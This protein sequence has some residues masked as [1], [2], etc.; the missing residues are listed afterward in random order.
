M[1]GGFI[2]FVIV[3]FA[4]GFCIVYFIPFV[5]KKNYN[6]Y[7]YT[8]NLSQ[9]EQFNLVKSQSSIALGFE[10]SYGNYPDLSIEDLVELKIRYNYYLND[11]KIRW[12]KILIFIN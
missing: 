8:I 1:I 10:C 9:T 2:N 11:R 4:L 6:L 5:K 3:G 12:K 7:Y